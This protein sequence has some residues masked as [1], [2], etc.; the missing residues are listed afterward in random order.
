[1]KKNFFLTQTV[2]DTEL[3]FEAIKQNT[4]ASPFNYV[5]EKAKPNRPDMGETKP[6]CRARL[7]VV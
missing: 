1:M 3:L 5:A 6:R 2:T 4:V 7:A